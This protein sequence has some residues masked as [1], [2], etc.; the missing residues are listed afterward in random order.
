MII[1]EYTGPLALVYVTKPLTMVCIVTV[2]LLGIR[3]V[4]GSRYGW[5]VVVALALSMAGDVLLMLPPDRF[6]QGLV[7]FLLAHLVYVAAF[8]ESVGWRG[9]VRRLMIFLLFGLSIGWVLWSGLG[10]MRLPVAIYILVI[11]IMGWR[12]WERSIYIG[13][14]GTRVAAIGALLFIISDSILALNRFR[15]PFLAAR[16]LNLSAYFSAQW[17]FALSIR[18]QEPR[19]ET[20]E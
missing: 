11:M 13:D 7:V 18:Q 20:S 12:A 2:A 5:L 6:V 15:E 3:I 8:V 9:S 16:A 17:L 14:P 10:G 19:T 4:G 1:G